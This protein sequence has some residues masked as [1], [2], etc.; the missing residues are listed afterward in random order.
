MQKPFCSLGC[1]LSH[2]SGLPVTFAVC[3]PVA[4]LCLPEHSGSHP[5]SAAT[6]SAVFSFILPMGISDRFKGEMQ[7]EKKNTKLVIETLCQC[8]AVLEQKIFTG[9]ILRVWMLQ[10]ADV[11]GLCQKTAWI[12]FRVYVDISPLSN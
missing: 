9:C 3:W 11:D 2:I 7:I 4:Y 8:G 12:C 6:L 1:S 10:E 5:G